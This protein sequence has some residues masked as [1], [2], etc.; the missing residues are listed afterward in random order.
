VQTGGGVAQ[1]EIVHE[2]LISSWPQLRRWLDESGEDAAFLDQLRTAAKQWQQKSKDVGL[3]WRGDMV[4]EAR[5]FQR[6]YRGELPK[7]LSEFLD[8]V[9]HQ[10]ARAA[11][12]KRNLAIA[13]VGL[14]GVIVVVLMVGLAT[15]AGLRSE[16][17]KQQGLAEQQAEAAKIA[18][19]T[20]TKAKGEAEKQLQIAQEKERQRAAAQAAAEKA[21]ADL[22][23][24]FEDLQ[25]STNKLTDALKAEEEARKHANYSKAEAETSARTARKARDEA[26]QAASKLNVQLQLER[27]RSRKLE[28]AQGGEAID[29]LKK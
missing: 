7:L 21:S 18:E 2:S 15:M 13:G 27:E 28:S 9:F 16:A 20:A 12:R 11:T 6:R 10:E 14:L 1:A 3:L 19:G 17:V 22:K 24:A 23:K 5:R 4:E 26:E 8:A 29:D 25:A